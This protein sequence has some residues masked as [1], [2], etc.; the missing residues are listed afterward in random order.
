MWYEVVDEVVLGSWVWNG[1]Y[2]V[3]VELIGCYGVGNEWV[4]VEFVFGDF[5]DKWIWSLEG[6]NVVVRYVW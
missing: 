1:V 3:V 6:L 4:C 5:V 2:C